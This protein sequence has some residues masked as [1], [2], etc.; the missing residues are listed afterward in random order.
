MY[1]FSFT[2]DAAVIVVVRKAGN[3]ILFYSTKCKEERKQ[4]TL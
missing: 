2:D 3:G 1:P 4:S